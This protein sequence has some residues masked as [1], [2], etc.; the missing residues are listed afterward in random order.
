MNKYKI[1]KTIGHGG[2]SDVFLAQ[3]IKLDSLR[4][5][6]RINKNHILHEQLLNEA[7]ILKDIRH[8]CIPTIYDFEEDEHYSYII[9]QY[10]NGQSLR[11][12][13]KQW[14]GTIDERL[15]VKIGIQICD[16][17]QYL[18]SLENPVLYLDLQPNNIIILD[19]KITL[20][21][22][23]ASSY[24]AQVSNR[25]YST[26]TRGFAAPELY[27]N[28]QP[29]E[30]T[31]IYG[32]GAL[33]YY[34]VTNTSYNSKTLLGDSNK[35]LKTCSKKMQRII[36]GCLNSNPFYRYSNIDKLKTKL[37]E[38]NEGKIKIST[39]A[40]NASGPTVIAIAG[41]QARIGTTHLSFLITS[42]LKQ[43]GLK[44]I[45]IESNDSY[46]VNKI[47]EKDKN[48][49]TNKGIYQVNDCN[50]VP[51]HKIKL[52]VDISKYN[53]QIV[54]YGIL[55][56]NNIND[57]IEA[58]IK[59]CVLGSKEWEISYSYQAIKLLSDKD[60]VKYLFNFIDS[61]RFIQL[62][63]DFKDF[64]CYRIPFEP[65]LHAKEFNDNTKQFMEEFIN[66]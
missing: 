9:E 45:Y 3:H 37:L 24:K 13:R 36:K 41:A 47:L 4:A 42:Y 64:P 19:N 38:I 15:V 46:H 25:K 29:S 8:T 44:S 40:S 17:L 66:Y 18:Y 22:F 61:E 55:T 51:H 27:G 20:I 1:L 2:S 34:M 39:K 10:I 43:N 60:N 30:R 54:D 58:D 59:A 23:G 28:R 7:H 21:D 26:G 14:L 6:K 62:V 48:I 16:L 12:F 53:F 50:I 56:Q 32:L 63:N 31:D 5:I 52:P 65:K 33:L 11:E 35:L 57:F 49:K